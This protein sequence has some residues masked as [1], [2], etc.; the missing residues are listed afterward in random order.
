M[1]LSKTTLAGHILDTEAIF[2]KKE[3]E[4]GGGGGER[5]DGSEKRQIFPKDK[6]RRF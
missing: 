2:N 4:G 3:E 6:N 5:G 1:N